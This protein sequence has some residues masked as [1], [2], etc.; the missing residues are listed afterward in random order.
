MAK[1]ILEVFAVD[2]GF[3]GGEVMLEVIEP[4]SPFVG[5]FAW[6]EDL[7]EATESLARLVWADEARQGGDGVDEPAEVA[8]VRI[9][10]LTVRTFDAAVLDGGEYVSDDELL[11]WAPRLPASWLRPTG[12]V[13]NALAAAVWALFQPGG[14]EEILEELL[15]LGGDGQA[16]AAAGGLLGAARGL[17]GIPERVAR[18]LE[19]SGPVLGLT[20]QLLLVRRR[21]SAATPALA[22]SR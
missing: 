19:A 6:G 5:L 13:L 14:L 8:G 22:G 15:G 10:A 20:P 7:G 16:L 21:H 12:D 2:S 3:D 11:A 18:S 9:L 4:S 1:T 17:G